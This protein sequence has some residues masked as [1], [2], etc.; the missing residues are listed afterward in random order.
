VGRLLF[1]EA[2][3]STLVMRLFFSAAEN[4]SRAMTQIVQRSSLT[5]YVHSFRDAPLLQR[6]QLCSKICE[7]LG[8]GH[9]LVAVAVTALLRCIQLAL[10]W[11]ETGEREDWSMLLKLKRVAGQ[12]WVEELRM[13][14]GIT[15]QWYEKNMPWSTQ[16]AKFK[17]RVVQLFRSI[18]EA[19]TPMDL[20]D[21]Q[22]ANI[23]KL[24]GQFSVALLPFVEPLLPYRE[25]LAMH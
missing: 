19:N 22:H 14:L 8:A 1:D 9:Y 7:V 24:E 25:F 2:V 18:V 23:R 6:W 3:V 21:V 16:D 13:M 15:L 20:T 17:S 10:G 5:A 12:D 11:H 4:E